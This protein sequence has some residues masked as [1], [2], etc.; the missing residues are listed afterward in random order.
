MSCT[1]DTE[2]VT[3]TDSS[4]LAH[5]TSTCPRTGFSAPNVTVHMVTSSLRLRSEGISGGP[6]PARRISF[7]TSSRKLK[8]SHVPMA[9]CVTRRLRPSTFCATHVLRGSGV[10]WEQLRMLVWRH[11]GGNTQNCAK[12]GSTAPKERARCT[13]ARSHAFQ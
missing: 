5:C 3:T 13:D 10:L 2:M 11:L 1:R 8:P 12:L 7:V 6:E 4:G 9:T